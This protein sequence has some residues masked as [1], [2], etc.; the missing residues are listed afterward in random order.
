MDGA[1]SLQTILPLP[2]GSA[3]SGPTIPEGPLDKQAFLYNLGFLLLFLDPNHIKA[4]HRILLLLQYTYAYVPG[5]LNPAMTFG[6][7]SFLAVELFCALFRS[8]PGLNP[9]DASSNLHS[10]QP[11]PGYDN[12]KCLQTLSNVPAGARSPPAENH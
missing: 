12:Q 1:S 11:T 8:I 6:A 3:N 5:F 4:R 2:W 7:E 9:L 10:P